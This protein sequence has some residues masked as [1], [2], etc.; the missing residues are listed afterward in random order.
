[1]DGRGDQLHRLVAKSECRPGCDQ[2]Q[3]TVWTDSNAVPESIRGQIWNITP[4][5]LCDQRLPAN[6]QLP[7]GP[8]RADESTMTALVPLHAPAPTGAKLQTPDCLRHSHLPDDAAGVFAPGW[9]VGRDKTKPPNRKVAHLAAYGLGNPFPEDAKLCAALSTFW[10]AVAPDSRRE[11]EPITGSQSGTVAPLT[12]EEIGQIGDMPWDG[13]PGPRVIVD[14][15]REFV[16][17]RDSRHVDYVRNALANKFTLQL[18]SQ[19]DAIEYENRIF[20]AALAY[21]AVGA[22]RSKSGAPINPSKLAKVRASLK[23]L[24]FRKVTH[25]TPDLE[26]A[27]RQAGV[28]LSGN[29]Y[30]IELFPKNK[31]EAIDGTFRR[32]VLMKKR[33]FLFVSPAAR[34]AAIRE[35]SQMSWSKAKIDV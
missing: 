5:S 21:L 8:F 2:R 27:K 16:E 10:P 1:L 22:A 15:R 20:A 13:V 33:Y 12:D 7:G 23:M 31:T 28:S 11:M 6:L 30:R 35:R 24:S 26:D 18:T 9:D 14:G 19:V 4:D 32:R 17:Y 29:V 34:Q 3:L 25:G